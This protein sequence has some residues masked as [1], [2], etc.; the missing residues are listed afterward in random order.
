MRKYVFCVKVKQ[1]DLQDAREIF[2][3][4]DLKIRKEVGHSWSKGANTFLSEDKDIFMSLVELL[5]KNGMPVKIYPAQDVTDISE[6]E[7]E[8][9]LKPIN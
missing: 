7:L 3:Q 6:E 9:F 5:I 4:S 8:E 2:E 1:R